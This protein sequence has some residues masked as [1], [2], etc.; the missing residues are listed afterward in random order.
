[1]MQHSLWHSYA[2]DKVFLLLQSDGTRGL[3]QA[4]ASNRLHTQGENILP[5]GEAEHLV[6]KLYRHVR[7]PLSAVLL[8]A[9]IATLALHEYL[10]TV[11][12]AVAITIN[13]AVSMIQEGRAQRVFATLADAQVR[14]ATVIRDGVQKVIL[15][16]QLVTGDIVLLQGGSAVP[17]DVRL[18]RAQALRVNEASLTGEWLPIE[19]IE[20][21]LGRALPLGEQRNMAWMGT[22]VTQGSGTGVVVSTGAHTRVGQFASAS[23]STSAKGANTPLQKSIQRLAHFLM[24]IVA[25]AV[26]LIL[27]VGLLRGEPL[28]DMLVLS[29]AIAV[30]T[31]PEGLPA[32][33]TVVLALGMESIMRKGGLV[34]NL[35]AAETL[36]STTVVMTD[37][38]GTLTQGRMTVKGLYTADGIETTRV[39]A[40]GDNKE[41]LKMAVLSSDAFVE[42]DPKEAGKIVVQGRPIEKAIAEGGLDAGLAQ[43]DLFSSGYNRLDF[44][45]F[46]PTR[47]YAVS[48]NENDSHHNRAYLSGSPEHLLAKADH[49]LRD[50]KAVALDDTTRSRFIDTQR[51]I[52]SEGMRFTAIAYVDTT[53]THVPDTV[54]NGTQSS[55]NIVFVGLIAFADAVRVEVSQAIATTQ[56]AGA[57]VIMATGDYPQT[58]R[59]IAREVGIDTRHDAPVLTGEMITNMNDL[60]LLTA[61]RSYNIIARVVPEQKLRVAHILRNAGEVVAMT[62][63]GVNDAPA[64]VA[65]DI[66]IAVGSGTDV[67]KAAADIVLVDNSF[68]VITAAIAE[69]RRVIANLRKIITYLL[70]TSFSEI[71]VI[72]GSLAVGAPLPLLP[73]QILWA[74]IVEEG[75]MSFP[76]AFE[77]QE[78][79]SMRRHPEKHNA[80]S[81]LTTHIRWLIFAVSAVTGGILLILYFILLNAGRPIEEV[82]TFMFVALSIDSIFFAFSFKDFTR[83]VWKIPLFSNLYLVGAL[84]ASLILLAAALVVPPLQE[85]LSLTTLTVVEVTLLVI[86]GIVNLATIEGAKTILHKYLVKEA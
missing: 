85:L 66:G 55:P 83:P 18:V 22:L 1:M 4:E 53:E 54:L 37:K 28:V 78:K 19:K 62:G 9:G 64:L 10:D 5:H 80:G 47:R 43:V 81:I 61:L 75:F 48:L 72:G 79:G 77:P 26:A 36:G 20:T 15:A 13:V 14:H 23:D 57:R 29:I 35:L 67:A 3:T 82:R 74:N 8:A 11:V 69:G 70:S 27:V 68:S 86:L 76:F 56:D 45:Q 25:G 2:R 12:I 65:A 31:M 16:T 50:G 38:T 71:V 51:S 7:A 52:S 30:A 33:V 46:E 34:K 32:A 84:V 17:A 59:A 41:L 6:H 40:E 42:H 58:A 49:Y 60:E 44:V 63:D 73:T 24:L 21:T 39:A